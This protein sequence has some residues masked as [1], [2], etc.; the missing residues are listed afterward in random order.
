[1]PA[2]TTTRRGKRIATRYDAYGRALLRSMGCACICGLGWAGRVRTPLDAARPPPERAQLE[3]PAGSGDAPTLDAV[4]ELP[5]PRP[6][7]GVCVARRSTEVP[8]LQ[9]RTVGLVPNK[10]RRCRIGA[11]EYVRRGES[12][13]DAARGGGQ[14]S[15]T[16]PDVRARGASPPDPSHRS[17]RVRKE[18]SRGPQRTRGDVGTL[19]A[20][21]P[22]RRPGGRD[23]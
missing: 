3:A 22:W 12:A 23:S 18:F 13:P 11:D 9:S 21:R 7:R 20:R 19:E 4:A 16:A 2:R 1:M 8:A 5:A 17:A 15:S 14:R 6:C 10:R